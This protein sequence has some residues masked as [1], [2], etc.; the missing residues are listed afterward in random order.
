MVLLGNLAIRAG[1]GVKVL[2]DGPN[3]R[4]TNLPELNQ[5]VRRDYRKGWSL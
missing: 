1:Q 4:S 5:F 2:W 3:M